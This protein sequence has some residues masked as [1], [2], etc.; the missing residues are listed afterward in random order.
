MINI[1][2]LTNIRILLPKYQQILLIWQYQS[3]IKYY[4][5]GNTE[6]LPNINY[7]VIPKYYQLATITYVNTKVL[8]NTTYYYMPNLDQYLAMPKYYQILLNW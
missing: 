8:P 5:F 2:I 4:I 1:R 6:V 3:I 7:L